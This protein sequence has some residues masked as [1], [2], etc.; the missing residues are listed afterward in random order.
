M[1]ITGIGVL[2]SGG[3]SLGDLLGALSANHHALGKLARFRAEDGGDLF[4][5]TIDDRAIDP[6][7]APAER[8]TM[9]RF[10]R[11]NVAGARR[12]IVCAGYTAERIAEGA[13]GDAGLILSTTFGPWESTNRFVKELID[14]GPLGT[15]ARVFPNTVL[16]S[17]QGRVAINLKMKGP[18]STICGAPALSYALDLLELGRAERVLAGGVDEIYPNL[19][20]AYSTDGTLAPQ[21]AREFLGRPFDP[22]SPGAT[23]AEGFA[24]CFV[25]TEESATARGANVLARI[26]GYGSASDG[27]L[28]RSFAHADR[29]GRAF[30]LAMRRALARAGLASERI[31]AVVAA[32]NGCRDLDAGE[33]VALGMT[34]GPAPRPVVA[35][36]SAT[37][38]CFG[39]STALGVATAV[40]LLGARPEL[41]CVLVNGVDIG[42]G[43]VS[44]VLGRAAGGAC[45]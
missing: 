28:A 25:E 43:H 9:D 41:G 26:L 45:S 27:R 23:A 14:E 4:G 15:S 44:F 30:A 8:R 32:A 18:C 31:D 36:K 13:L 22:E 6:W 7:I 3:E 38:E 1:V 42:G 19:L 29:E 35:P 37:G 39:A 12:T 2:W 33:R 20:T 21:S 16:N 24:A 5:G 40:G 17:A 11:L 34:L 10:G